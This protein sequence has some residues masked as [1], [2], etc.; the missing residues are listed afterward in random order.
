[1]VQILGLKIGSNLHYIMDREDT[2]NL[3]RKRRS[4]F[5]FLNLLR[6]YKKEEK[7]KNKQTNERTYIVVFKQSQGR[8]AEVS[9]TT[10]I[11]EPLNVS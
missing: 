6:S 9:T 11:F 2:D 10:L 5:R 8:H 3:R 7:K 4:L 1:M